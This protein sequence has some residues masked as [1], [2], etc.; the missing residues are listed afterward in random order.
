MTTTVTRLPTAATS[1]YEVRH[2]KGRWHFDLV[3]PS[4]RKPS[5]TTLEVFGG[6]DA[7]V[8]HA[9]EAGKRAKRPVKLP[10]GVA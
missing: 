10:K 7:A 9:R 4:A 5:R 6:L 1:F 3:T 2:S 8:A